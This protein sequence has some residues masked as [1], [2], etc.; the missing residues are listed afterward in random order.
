MSVHEFKSTLLQL[1]SCKC[2]TTVQV[3]TLVRHPSKNSIGIKDFGDRHLRGG[4]FLGLG[5]EFQGVYVDSAASAKA[6]KRVLGVFC[7]F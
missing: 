4:D 3:A 5:V 1:I 6:L 7:L 2:H